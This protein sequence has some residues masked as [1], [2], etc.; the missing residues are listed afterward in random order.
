MGRLVVVGN[1]R[2]AEAFIRE[3]Q[4]YDHDFSITVF[5]GGAPPRKPAWYQNRGV[6]LRQGVHIVAIDR[7][8]RIVQG[9]D[10]S[11]TTFD[12]LILATG[13][14]EWRPAGLDVRRGV[15]V[16]RCLESSDGHIYAIGDCA[17]MRDPEWT[18]SLDAQARILAEQLARQR[19]GASAPQKRGIH[20]ARRR[21]AFLPLVLSGV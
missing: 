21:R 4:K 17:E 15:V 13:Q 19:I 5:S 11:R 9:D 16:N 1:G 7:H 18:P 14:S 3:I 10:G 12:R 6:D 8:A 2:A 20:L